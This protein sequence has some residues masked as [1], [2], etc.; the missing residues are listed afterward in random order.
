M[1]RILLN[2][3][4]TRLLVCLIILSSSACNGRAPEQSSG[5]IVTVSILPQAYLV[6]RIGGAFVN[7]VTLVDP[8]ESPA[9]YQPSDRKVSRVL[10]SKVYFR[11]GV[12]FEKGKWSSALASAKGEL[13]VKDLREGIPLRHFAEHDHEEE[14]GDHDHGDSDPHI[15]L[16]P[17][18]LKIQA[19]TVAEV[20]S[21]IDPEHSDTYQ[22]N[23][24]AFLIDMDALEIE[25]QT[26][27]EPYRG[28]RVYIYHPAWGYFCDA[29]GLEQRAI[30]FAGKEPSDAELTELQSLIR[31]DGA[32]VIFVQPQIAGRSVEA[33]AQAVGAEVRVLD[34]LA[35]DIPAN[36]IEA[37][38]AMAGSFSP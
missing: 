13:L 36:L 34:P 1:K 31:A 37:A 7:V 23:L 12:P 35:R 21:K 22:A 10:Q 14:H 8:G 9:T 6:E 2:I 18:L 27:L 30:E 16:S 3:P 32:R 5:L 4:V 20:L 15:W 38:K 17:G 25:I 33:V 28:K 29:Y 24:N 26:I 19:Q 11:I